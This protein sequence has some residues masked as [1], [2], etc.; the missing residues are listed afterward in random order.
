MG[1]WIQMTVVIP[2]EDI[3]KLLQD[4]SK[5]ATSL[6]DGM[7]EDDVV[8]FKLY[9]QK[10]LL[11]DNDII[12]LI[13]RNRLW[14]NIIKILPRLP[15][16]KR[17]SVFEIFWGNI[18]AFR[19]LFDHLSGILKQLSFIEEANLDLHSLIPKKINGAIPASIIDVGTVREVVSKDKLDKKINVYT[20]N[21]ITNSFNIGDITAIIKELTLTVDDRVISEKTFLNSVDVLD[22][23]QELE[24]RRKFDLNT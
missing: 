22:F 10:Y 19:Q 13:N 8:E 9:A 6:Q 1:I 24:N 18:K 2:Y 3:V 20:Q 5:D 15:W 7:S 12:K 17:G 14:E 4:L 16:D 11:V 23:S 21:G